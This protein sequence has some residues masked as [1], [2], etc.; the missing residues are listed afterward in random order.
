[1]SDY[2]R[3]KAIR[4]LPNEG[5]LL[6]VGAVGDFWVL[7]ESFPEEYRKYNA[8]N[9]KKA[10]YFELTD[11]SE[12]DYIDFVLEYS[13]GDECGD[14]G[15]V[16]HLTSTELAKAVKLFSKLFPNPNPAN[17][18]LV[19]YCYY[20]CCEPDDYFDPEEDEFYKEVHIPE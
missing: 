9:T 18:R 17:F 11:T 10:G 5:D 2:V 12:R 1:M 14:F 7:E 13:Y 20:N 15:K 16:R 3:T 19:D 8:G 6:A 4:Y